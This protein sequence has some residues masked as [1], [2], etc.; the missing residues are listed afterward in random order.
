VSLVWVT[1]PMLVRSEWWTPS[2]FDP[3][4]LPGWALAVAVVVYLRLRHL[5]RS[6]A[7][8]LA[9]AIGSAAV[10]VERL[11]YLT[12]ALEYSETAHDSLPLVVAAVQVGLLAAASLGLG[13][14]AAVKLRHLPSVLST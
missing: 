14:I 8:A 11:A 1:V 5:D 6:G 4:T 7:R 2:A 12:F 9:L 13:T 3:G 10:L